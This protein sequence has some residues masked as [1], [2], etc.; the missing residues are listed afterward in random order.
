MPDDAQPTTPPPART[1][2]RQEEFVRLLNGA[3]ALLLRYVTS[4]VANRHDAEDVMQRASVVMWKRFGTFESGTDF[5]AWATT[6]AF[7]E[8]RNFQRVTGRSRPEFDDDL[9]QTLAAAGQL[10]NVQRLLFAKTRAPEELYDLAADPAQATTL[11]ELRSKLD[12]W[13]EQTNDQGR[14]PGPDSRYDADMAVYQG[15]KPNPEVTKNIAL[16]KQWTREGK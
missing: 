5:V 7:Y 14:P 1:P 8:V 9:M 6:V 16:M 3:H 12:R 11:Q 2:G 10:N 13:M 4:L 15:R